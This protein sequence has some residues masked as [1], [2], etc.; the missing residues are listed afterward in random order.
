MATIISI[1]LCSFKLP[2][3]NPNF[4]LHHASAIAGAAHV[5]LC[6]FG[7][8]QEAAELSLG[9]SA[10]FS[11]RRVNGGTLE[12]TLAAVKPD[13]KS[14]RLYLRSRPS[15][16]GHRLRGLPAPRMDC[17]GLQFLEVGFTDRSKCHHCSH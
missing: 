10:R 4:A 17:E 3:A 16:S 14:P 13:L 2:V 15:N 6:R 8:R 7:L 1:A 11:R 12:A 9:A 5:G